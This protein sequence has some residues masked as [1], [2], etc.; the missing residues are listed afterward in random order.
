MFTFRT[1]KSASQMKH[2]ESE[3]T[4]T[5][6]SAQRSPFR[7]KQ[8][9]IADDRCAMKVGTDGI[10]LGAWANPGSA[11][12]IADF[13]SGSGL[14]A[15]MLAQRTADNVRID[16]VEIDSESACQAAGNID[17]SPWSSRVSVHSVPVQQFVRR[18]NGALDHIVCNPPFFE[19]GLPSPA[20]GRARARHTQWLSRE[21][22]FQSAALALRASGRI[23]LIA[24][25]SDLEAITETA[26]DSGLHLG[27]LTL[28]SPLPGRPPKRILAEYSKNPEDL[29]DRDGTRINQL[30]IE[31]QHHQYT[32]AFLELTGAFYLKR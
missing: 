17:A 8:F 7:F 13:G 19:T 9:S 5:N 24:P 14:I 29:I 10:L 2:P 25:Y 30:V 15:L 16:A 12:R 31:H 11:T 26:R 27:R 22:L 28:V 1:G 32:E 6:S 3:N 18:V 20:H 4:G 23:S 21:A